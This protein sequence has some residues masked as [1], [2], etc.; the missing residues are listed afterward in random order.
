MALSNKKNRKSKKRFYRKTK[1]II[2]L[3][4]KSRIQKGS[5]LSNI[6]PV[7][8]KSNIEKFMEKRINN[9]NI[10]KENLSNL[11][12]CLKE[13]DGKLILTGYKHPIIFDKQIGE[14]SAN[15]IVYMVHIEEGEDPIMFSAKIIKDNESNRNEVDILKQLEKHVLD[16]LFYFPLIYTS[17]TCNIICNTPACPKITKQN[18]IVVLN[19]LANGDANWWFKKQTYS[20][21]VYKSVILQMIY[22]IYNLHKI[23]FN[24]NDMHLGNLLV[25]ETIP[26]GV[27]EYLIDGE[28]ITVQ[29]N[30]YLLVIW[31]FGLSIPHSSTETLILK[32]DKYSPVLWDYIVILEQINE[33][34]EIEIIPEIK[35]WVLKIYNHIKDKAET[36]SE[37][38][39]ILN[40]PV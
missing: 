6:D 8:H 18:Y 36:V 24:H 12:P 28:N 3:L 5:A 25:H 30:G 23:G 21:E 2:R 11:N 1:K 29:N 35:E 10:L 7:S 13:E 22:A 27:F 33:I 15:G 34:S 40:L 17:L 39:I 19:E 38:N 4:Q 37:A 20:Y 9:Y 14:S 32:G 26:G 31:D 16:G